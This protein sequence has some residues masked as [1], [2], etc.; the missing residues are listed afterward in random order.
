MLFKRVNFELESGVYTVAGK[1][2]SGKSQLLMAIAH[3]YGNNLLTQYGFNR[4]IIDE[5]S[6]QINPKPRKVL[7]RPPIRKIGEASRGSLYA[8][9]GPTSYMDIDNFSG[10]TFSVDERFTQLHNRIANIFVAGTIQNANEQNKKLWRTISESFTRVFHK[11][12][13]GK[14]NPQGGRIGLKLENN[15]VSNFSTLSSGEQE[16]LSLVCDLI[17]EPEVD[18]FLID[19][20]DLHF[21][22]DLQM[23]VLNE[24]EVHLKD[25]ILLATT[26]SPSVALRCFCQKFFEKL[27]IS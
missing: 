17:T 18:L 25:R 19:E 1:N 26:H 21:H 20:I 14:F 11:S 10:Y 7:W 5:K 9:M 8:T 13:D 16:F 15:E 6:V 22:P 2:G 24:I 3:Q 4:D 27:D 23:I 12:I